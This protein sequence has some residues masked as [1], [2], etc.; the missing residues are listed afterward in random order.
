VSRTDV[1]CEYPGPV[2][3]VKCISGDTQMCDVTKCS[4]AFG[5]SVGRYVRDIS[6]TPK[7][8]AATAAA[9]EQLN[10]L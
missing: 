8:A 2:A 1:K 7:A 6:I 4:G 5:R 9:R 10:G 3:T